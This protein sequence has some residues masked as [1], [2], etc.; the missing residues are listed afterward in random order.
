MK[1][2][3]RPIC[4]NADAP[5]INRMRLQPGVMQNIASLPTETPAQT[6]QLLQQETTNGHGLVAETTLEDGTKQVV[7]FGVLR[8]ESTSRMR[9]CG[10]VALIVDES[11]Q[12]QGIG[13]QLL[14][15]LLDMADQWLMLTRVELTVLTDNLPA[16]GLYEKMGFE[17]EGVLRKTTVVNGVYM[18]DY[19][20][21]RIAKGETQGKECLA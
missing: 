8:L 6:L 18:D 2:V 19:L 10:N 17:K 21:A 7:G 1:F 15:G 20:M 9:H 11:Y 4:L 5:D 13:R 12:G 14:A 3:I 16:I